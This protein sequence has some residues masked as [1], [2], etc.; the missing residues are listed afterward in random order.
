M[1]IDDLGYV[2]KD[3]GKRY[4]KGNYTTTEAFKKCEKILNDLKKHQCGAPFLFPVQVEGYH[5]KIKEPM[6]LTTVERKLKNGAYP[7]TTNF[8]QDV[9]KIWTNAWSYN[10]P[11]T[12]IYIATTE[13]SHLFEEKVQELGDVPLTES[14]SN[15]IE[16]LK[17]QVNKM[18]G[19]IKRI[20]SVGSTKGISSSQKSPMS[21]PMTTQEKAELKMNI[22]NL[23]PDKLPGVIEII[24]FA[25]DTTQNKDTLEFDIDILPPKCCRELELYVKKYM[26]T[27]QKTKKKPVK[28]PKAQMQLQAQAKLVNKIK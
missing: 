7:S 20:T 28:K 25:V 12:S 22:M 10:M 19:A 24:K 6:D 5:E 1:T 2:N 23:P 17:K 4:G 3:Q 15:E 16:E 21:R 9:R 14:A 11:G 13:I 18:T 27:S 8:I 26:Q